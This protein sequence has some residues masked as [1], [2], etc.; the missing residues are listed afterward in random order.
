MLTSVR[1]LFAFLVVVAVFDASNGVY[2]TYK[3]CDQPVDVIFVFD[4]KS[5]I[6]LAR[7]VIVHYK[8]LLV[9]ETKLK[10]GVAFCSK[11]EVE[12]TG[13]E[14]GLSHLLMITENLQHA[15]LASLHPHDTTHLP[16]RTGIRAENTPYPIYEITDIS[17]SSDSCLKT[18]GAMFKEHGSDKS[19]KLTVVVATKKTWAD[20]KH[21]EEAAALKGPSFNST[22]A[23]IAAG[24]RS[25]GS[26]DVL[27]KMASDPSKF[28]TVSSTND[29]HDVSNKF[30]QGACRLTDV[31]L[32]TP[33]FP[34]SI[35]T[36]APL[37]CTLWSSFL[38]C[39]L[40]IP[41]E[42]NS[43]CRELLIIRTCLSHFHLLF[44]ASSTTGRMPVL[45]DISLLVTLGSHRI[46]EILLRHIPQ[47]P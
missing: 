9:P 7:D 37:K 46:P 35:A 3:S 14:A 39:V 12:H 22:V 44:F 18:V 26:R 30:A 47:I 43:G 6:S 23:V 45:S 32:S 1:I 13:P 17:S 2:N 10:F 33:S 24:S 29:L 25:Y 15:D 16:D 19:T 5:C 21:I 40:W 11:T 28:M 4:D 20:P 34:V 27:E 36:M 42:S 31:D 38:S 8:S 41:C